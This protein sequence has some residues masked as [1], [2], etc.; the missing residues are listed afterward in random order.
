M[1]Y[2]TLLS[3]NFQFTFSEMLRTDRYPT[4]QATG[5][6]VEESGMGWGIGGGGGRR[7][8]CVCRPV[9]VVVECVVLYCTEADRH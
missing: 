2:F 9:V 7:G 3:G 6:L 1:L 5:S 4:A 8:Q